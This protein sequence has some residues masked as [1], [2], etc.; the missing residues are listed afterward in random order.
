ME[1]VDTLRDL[2]KY[3]KTTWQTRFEKAKLDNQIKAE[4]DPKSIAE[5][6]TTIIQGM[7]LKAK[8]GA[9]KEDLA[10]TSEIALQTL[11]SLMMKN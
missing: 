10:A 7:A 5:F 1:H 11:S 3:Y 9:D 6:F 8:D 4:T 2:R